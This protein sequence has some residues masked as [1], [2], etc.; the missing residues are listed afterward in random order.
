MIAV[1][2]VD[3]NLRKAL[4]QITDWEGKT[5]LDLGAGTGRFPLVFRNLDCRFIAL[6]LYR[7]MLIE[8]KLQRDS[9]GANWPL[10]QADMRSLPF[11]DQCA[12]IVIAGWSIGHLRTWYAGNWQHE[13]GLILAE[14]ARAARPGGSI[15]ICETMS[16][17]SLVP[18]P[19]A[20]ELAEYYHWLETSH[21][22]TPQVIQTD[23]QFESVEQ[24]V[25]HTTF[26]FG[27]DLAADIQTQGWARLPEWTGIWSRQK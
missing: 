9:S 22:F 5:I 26:F 23:Y 8:N 1:E 20:P 27:P 6:D 18:R 15:I 2:D 24:A 10:V 17:G 7:A 4:A 11:D 16:T 14:M 25:A 3:G 13:I 12:D 21:G 19:P